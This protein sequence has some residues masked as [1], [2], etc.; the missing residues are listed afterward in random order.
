M[1]RNYDN[2]LWVGTT[3]GIV[4]YD[5][6]TQQVTHLTTDTENADQNISN[7]WIQ[8]IQFDNK[9]NLWIATAAG[10]NKLNLKTNA[11]TQYLKNIYQT[12][13]M[14]VDDIISIFID[15]TGLIWLGTYT[16]GVY[17]FNPEITG[18][19]KLLTSSDTKGISNTVHGISKDNLENLW[20]AAFG[21]GVYQLNLVTGKLTQAF[22]SQTE[23]VELAYSLLFD[24][25][26]RLWI[27]TNQGFFI[28]DGTHK[29][30]LPIKVILDDSEFNFNYYIFQIYEDSNGKIWIA[31][32]NGLY[33]VDKVEK[34]S[35]EYQITI[36]NKTNELPV[37]FRNRSIMVSAIFVSKNEDIWI[38]GTAGLA[39]YS[40]QE[41]VWFHYQYDRLNQK[42][43]SNNDVQVIYEDSRGTLW[44]GTADGL[45]KVNREN[46]NNIYF[47][48]ITR[49]HGLPNNSIYGILEDA[50]GSVWLS[51]NQGIVRYSDFN[52][53]LKTYSYEDGISSN[54]FNKNAFFV[55]EYGIMYFGSIN[56]V[57]SISEISSINLNRD[58]QLVFTSINIDD[59]PLDINKI[60]AISNPSIK[61]GVDNNTIKIKVADLYY[62]QLKTQE[63]RYRISS[64]ANKWINLKQ[65]RSIVLSGL[66][67]GNY[68]LEIQSKTKNEKWDHN[69]LK[70]DIVV[71]QSFW[72]SREAIYLLTLIIFSILCGLGVWVRTRFIMQK[73]SF[74]SQL[75][76]GKIRIKEVK[77]ENDDY[78]RVIAAN[79]Q[80]HKELSDEI[81][82]LQNQVA[83]FQFKDPATGL[84]RFEMLEKTIDSNT[85]GLLINQYNLIAL[86]SIDNY[87]KLES[88]YNQL[89]AQV[90]RQQIASVIKNNL[91]ANVKVL[92][93]EPNQFV[94]LANTNL[95]AQ[96]TSLLN[97]L[98][99]KLNKFL[100][101]IDNGITFNCYNS[102]IYSE[103]F[104]ESINKLGQF[105][106]LVNLLQ[107]V[108][109]YLLK[110][111]KSNH[112][113]VDINISMELIENNKLDVLSMIENNFITLHHSQE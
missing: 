15:R 99:A 105:F 56:G 44:I 96:L 64:L 9:E 91:P 70:L 98:G 69:A 6:Q 110:Q 5:L 32:S 11:I 41:E 86:F 40:Q 92:S 97:N 18:I 29:K 90:I 50:K 7:G 111:Q 26:M 1:I 109:E 104:T 71:N 68:A 95:N 23:N 94:V 81:L 19:T 27:G 74:R 102:Y 12:D 106:A 76:V 47:K 88:Q 61:V 14:R 55:D 100:V 113:R 57:T 39:H 28:S 8:D 53:T 83:E 35:D 22:Q 49:E 84:Y 43:I 10:L 34:K 13:G 103:N 42:T 89:N 20:F 75:K 101:A 72:Q 31:T 45:N 85:T 107:R 54:E 63:Y 79:L 3:D 65:D 82:A 93:L 80:K 59:K 37:S 52:E 21:S 17:I 2:I 67:H 48:R 30:L 33:W 46:V 78:R 60:N 77:N 38:G 73:S 16:G 108:Q 24:R 112:L 58:K 87:K 51:T 62:H 4:K 25:K 36:V 66:T